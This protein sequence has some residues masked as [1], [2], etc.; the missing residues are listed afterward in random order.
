MYIFA[1]V[2][3]GEVSACV[4]NRN[5]FHPHFSG[6]DSKPCLGFCGHPP[7]AGEPG[8]CW[9]SWRGAAPGSGSALGVGTGREGPRVFCLHLRQFVHVHLNVRTFCQVPGHYL[10][11][12][13]VVAQPLCGKWW[14][15]HY[16]VCFHQSP[17]TISHW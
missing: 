12:L 11:S 17:G 5:F 4:A 13:H 14:V 8:A 3:C 15:S 10:V 9:G 1:R 7:G 16:D 2:P 6:C